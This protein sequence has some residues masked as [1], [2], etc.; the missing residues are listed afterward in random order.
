MPWFYRE[1]L[2]AQKDAIEV[3]ICTDQVFHDEGV[4]VDELLLFVQ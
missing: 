4:T 2:T 3:R 1:F